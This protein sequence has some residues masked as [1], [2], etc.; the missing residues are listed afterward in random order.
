VWGPDS[1][2]PSGEEEGVLMPRALERGGYY[3]GGCEPASA[4]ERQT[5]TGEAKQ[6]SVRGRLREKGAER[7]PCFMDAGRLAVG[8]EWA[9]TSVA[10][11]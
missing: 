7:G 4:R 10:V 5:V 6:G 2:Q 9:M 1:T 3:E 8:P 11:G